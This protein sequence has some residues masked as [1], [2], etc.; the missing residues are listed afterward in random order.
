[1]SYYKSLNFFFILLIA[2]SILTN[3]IPIL[4]DS[5]MEEQEILEVNVPRLRGN[6]TNYGYETFSNGTGTYTIS[7]DGSIVQTSTFNSYYNPEPRFLIF[8]E[9]GPPSNDL[10]MRCNF[11]EG[12]GTDVIINDGTLAGVINGTTNAGW[13]SSLDESFNYSHV[14]DETS[15]EHINFTDRDEL[16]FDKAG[17]AEDKPFTIEF[18]YSVTWAFP[19]FK[20]IFA[21]ANYTSSVY[22]WDFLL[23]DEGY[24]NFNLYDGDGTGATFETTT[25]SQYT[26]DNEWTHVAFSYF[27]NLKTNNSA[28]RIY[29]NGT[30]QTTSTISSGTQAAYGG[31]N[32]TDSDFSLGRISGGY[33]DGWFDEF[34]IWNKS[35]TASEIS[36]LYNNAPLL[37]YNASLD[38]KTKLIESSPYLYAENDSM[39]W[40]GDDM[41]DWINQ[42]TPNNLTAHYDMETG[43]GTTLYDVENNHDATF[44]GDIQWNTTSVNALANGSIYFD[45][46]D[47]FVRIPD[48]DDF[49]FTNGTNYFDIPYS[50]DLWIYPHSV[51]SYRT[52]IQK[53]ESDTSGWEEWRLIIYDGELVFY[54]IPDWDIGEMIWVQT[55]QADLTAYN[56]YHITATYD[57]SENKN[58]LEVYVNGEVQPVTRWWQ[59]MTGYIGMKNG[60]TEVIMGAHYLGGQ[61]V[62]EFVGN[63]DE[64]RIWR[65][66]LGASE[67]YTMYK[68][69][70]YFHVDRESL[71]INCTVTYNGTAGLSHINLTQSWWGDTPEYDLTGANFDE[72]H[73]IIQNP[74]FELP[75]GGSTDPD[76]WTGLRQ[77]TGQARTGSWHGKVTLSPNNLLYQSIDYWPVSMVK[78]VTLWARKDGAGEAI[79]N[80]Y[81]T[82]SDATQS[83]FYLNASTTSYEKFTINQTDLEYTKI[84]TEL[85][86][87][88]NT[89]YYIGLI[90]DV[91]IYLQPMI[92]VSLDLDISQYDTQTG[93]MCVSV[94]SSNPHTTNSTIEIDQDT[95]G[96]V[97]RMTTGI[98]TSNN[99]YYNT[100]H[101]HTD[102]YFS[103]NM[104]ATADNFVING[105]AYDIGGSGLGIVNCTNTWGETAPSNSGTNTSWSFSWPIDESWTEYGQIQHIDNPDFEDGN[106]DWTISGGSISGTNERRSHSGAYFLYL[107]AYSNA[108]AYQNVNDIPVDDVEYLYFWLYCNWHSLETF[109]RYAVQLTV[110]YN[111]TTSTAWNF[112]AQGTDNY[113]QMIVDTADLSAGKFIS[114]IRFDDKLPNTMGHLIYIDDV[115]LYT[116]FDNITDS[117]SITAYDNVGNPQD[118]FNYS[119]DLLFYVKFDLFA[120][121]QGG[122]GVQSRTINDSSSYDWPIYT[123]WDSDSGFNASSFVPEAQHSMC[124]NQTP[125]DWMQPSVSTKVGD[126]DR[127]AF[128]SSTFTLG[129][130]VNIA[131]LET[132]STPI[133]IFYR[134]Q[135]FWVDINSQNY[136]VGGVR[137]VDFEL[138]GVGTV[139]SAYFIPMNQWTFVVLRWNGSEG[140]IFFNGT[141]DVNTITG[142]YNP[143]AGDF[144]VVFGN[145]YA[146]V[147]Y[148]YYLD[149]L[150]FYTTSLSDERIELMYHM[151]PFSPSG[152]NYDDTPFTDDYDRITFGFTNDETAPSSGASFDPM[153]AFYE[154]GDTDETYYNLTSD[155][156]WFSNSFD[157][158][159]NITFEANV[160]DLGAGM[161]GVDYGTFGDDDPAEDQTTPY[162]GNYTINS[163]DS[164][165]YLTVIAYDNVGNSATETLYCYEDGTALW[166]NIT[167]ETENSIYLY[168]GYG[169]GTQGFYGSAMGATLQAFNISG[170]TYTNVT[171]LNQTDFEG[172]FT[173][174]T[175]WTRSGEEGRSTVEWEGTYAMR[176]T[177]GTSPNYDD[178]W[179][180]QTCWIYSD[181]IA[182]LT[183]MLR[184]RADCDAYIVF[185]YTDGSNTTQYFDGSRDE[186]T[187]EQHAISPLPAGKTINKIRFGSNYTAPSANMVLID[188]IKLTLG[189]SG[190]NF[191]DNSTFGNN[192][193][194]GG[195]IDNWFFVYQIDEN[196]NGNTTVAFVSYDNVGNNYSRN[197]LFYEDNVAPNIDHDPSNT[198]ETSP[199][200]YY[201]NDNQTGYYSENMP[202]GTDP[203]ENYL[204]LSL[205]FDEGTGS[206]TYDSSDESRTITEVTWDGDEWN[207]TSYNGQANYSFNCY[208]PDVVWAAWDGETPDTHAWSVGGWFALDPTYWDGLNNFWSFVDWTWY[209]DAFKFYKHAN[210]QLFIY[211]RGTTTTG[212][213]GTTTM[214][215]TQAF[216]TAWNF[217]VV[218]WDGNIA[219]DPKLYVNGT[220]IALTEYAT[221]SGSLRDSDRFY[222]GESTSA[223][224]YGQ[225]DSIFVYNTNISATRIADMYGYM[226]A[227]FQAGESFFVGG[228][229]S[230]ALGITDAGVVDNTTAFLDPSNAGTVS[231]WSFEYKIGYTDGAT[232]GTINVTYTVIDWVGNSNTTWFYF[233]FDNQGPTAVLESDPEATTYVDNYHSDQTV[234][235]TVSSITDGF[236][237]TGSGLNQSYIRWKLDGGSWG[238]WN[239]TTIR[240]YTL[241]EGE[242]IFYI[243]LRDNVTNIREYNYTIYVDLTD[244]IIGI[245]L[246]LDTLVNGGFESGDDGNWTLYQ[247]SYSTQALR[248]HSGTYGMQV[249]VYS[250]G[251]YYDGYIE[252][253][254][255]FY[256]D[257][258]S[259]FT[260][261]ERSTDTSGQTTWKVTFHYSDGTSNSWSISNHEDFNW[262]QRTVSGWSSGK[263]LMWF[264]LETI[265]D[266]GDNTGLSA[267]DDIVISGSFTDVTTDELTW[268]DP[269]Y[270]T[271][272]YR[273]IDDYANFNVTWTELYPYRV[274]CSNIP[275]SYAEDDGPAPYP[276]GNVSDFTITIT[277][278]ADGYYNIS[279]TI[280]DR[281]GRKSTVYTTSDNPNNLIIDNTGP[282]ISVFQLVQHPEALVSNYYKTT[283][284]ETTLSG[285]S[286]GVN[287]SGLH[288]SGF[289]Y[290][291][292]VN[293]DGWQSWTAV[294]NKIWTTYDQQNNTLKVMARDNLGWNSSVYLEWVISDTIAPDLGWLTL[295]E[296]YAPNWFDQ[297]VSTAAGVTIYWT[298]PYPFNVTLGVSPFLPHTNDTSP[299][300]GVS[301]LWVNITG[302]SDGSYALSVT[303]WDNAGNS[304]NTLT[305]S[306]AP[307]NLE[308]GMSTRDIENWFYFYFFRADGIGLDWR[309]FNTS[310]ILDEN[311][312]PYVE[313]RIRGALFAQKYLNLTSSIRFVVRNY[314]GDTVHNQSYTLPTS[315]DLYITL[316][317]YTFKVSNLYDEVMNM[318]IRR[319]SS[320]TIYRE[321]LMPYE[322]FS[323]DMYA[324]VYNITVYIHDTSIIALDEMGNQLIDYQVNLTISDFALF[325]DAP[326]TFRELNMI[327]SSIWQFNL[328]TNKDHRAVQPSIYIYLNDSLQGGGAFTPGTVVLSRPTYGYYNLTIYAVWQSY[329]FTYQ[330]WITVESNA[331]LTNFV[332]AGLEEANDYLEISWNTNKGTGRLTIK[333]NTST[334][335]IFA[336]EGVSELRKSTVVGLH[337]LQFII[338]VE[339]LSFDDLYLNY[340]IPDWT[341]IVSISLQGE[342]DG[343]VTMYEDQTIVATVTRSDGATFN[344]LV[345]INGTSFTITSGTGSIV[346]AAP[347]DDGEGWRE[348][349]YVVTDVQDGVGSSRDY[350]ANDLDVIWDALQFSV[351]LGDPQVY[352]DE[353]ASFF[354]NIT[355]KYDDNPSSQFSFN[356]K[357]NDTFIKSVTTT[358]FE[359]TVTSAGT[360]EI[361]IEAIRDHIYDIDYSSGF[362]I[363]TF[364]AIDRVTPA[365]ERATQ[366]EEL[367][368]TAAQ[369]IVILAVAIAAIIAYYRVV[370]PTWRRWQMGG[371]YKTQTG[372]QIRRMTGKHKIQLDSNRRRHQPSGVR[373]RPRLSSR[374]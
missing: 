68:S 311:Y 27:G 246:G 210:D 295:N 36:W 73:N 172:S 82:Y 341:A 223:S 22:E 146:N 115:Y 155:S 66:E 304:D 349:T 9:G 39:L 161:R 119:E 368:R 263:V 52:L 41:V 54:C 148:D 62:R 244:P 92:E 237:A 103:D 43:Y 224:Y 235:A 60:N 130:W 208:A 144:S 4:S 285:A 288:D 18:W 251:M 301:N 100:T 160:T 206:D 257:E 185:F 259:S 76:H 78:N 98:E 253:N 184:D 105:T 268:I 80:T 196:D 250:G 104:G 325:V 204:N 141:K 70:P 94:W 338:D 229:A 163:T 358:E 216:Y 107:N 194:N 275:L 370:R 307:I 135:G 334:V 175:N 348:L 3:A 328:I 123:T 282:T 337:M 281:S 10:T 145:R 57:G 47:D 352:V 327:I 132:T 187:Y 188:Y 241:S 174:G 261:Y 296:S 179:I 280:F 154:V 344:G 81:I 218:T 318:T 323:W 77:N 59:G 75:A 79:I 58:G 149:D 274:N 243:Q 186:N 72:N 227:L 48:H 350:V 347:P 110:E 114:R 215:A 113:E 153:S 262:Y 286:D 65:R 90:D 265:H 91:A 2:S 354:V 180:E 351:E 357:L 369:W 26:H 315:F 320:A 127:D 74:S 35:L 7:T 340:T 190:D 117:T 256:T 329:D 303:M 124:W 266:N 374:R 176:I 247:S 372:Q 42:T 319:P 13:D 342:T 138:Y 249:S 30:Y 166:V 209:E 283:A 264:R 343:R 299:S 164:G 140:A 20:S 143:T 45:G 234:N 23:D 156:F 118:D 272:F 312:R 106:Q 136:A 15:Q 46:S 321:Q 345:E 239:T 278:A 361:K 128:G 158:D 125:A 201:P 324:A 133:G 231:N 69:S 56:W 335:A 8:Q 63:M 101:Y 168:A 313:Q 269:S 314:F 365:A 162:H 165:V 252:Q 44:N 55:T 29:V 16:S 147:D 37:P 217:Y 198:N 49:T 99:L 102:G 270:G 214:P 87:E 213:W 199:Y 326:L 248:V 279:A 373:N 363:R 40:Y 228:T 360:W 193:T 12:S 97:M 189:G 364:T 121:G 134:D 291:Y 50:I 84:I 183:F 232:Y 316:D 197:Y 330:R 308:S 362:K 53:Y 177:N 83:K 220:E 336:I 309:D 294:T 173:W 366:E 25:W 109:D 95:I 120:S 131:R 85:R 108:Y 322:I 159:T 230:D 202:P 276:S 88:Y 284:P 182:S 245:Y 17:S 287:G 317:V 242:H 236:P 205:L 225:I 126:P 207:A 356:V 238:V 139:R 211:I 96:P 181:M 233:Y 219:N 178:G 19:I 170:I 260:F 332:V 258:I 339:S 191:N 150:F 310:Y 302:A 28:G 200:L 71:Q 129:F 24:L 151:M 89:S 331:E 359:I 112:T 142:T 353:P 367:G 293:N 6:S 306:E 33:M 271:Q 292:Q 5:D 346:I 333:D 297:S 38:I 221:I 300:G 226:P 273:A 192:P 51:S 167:G 203:Y 277:G 61:W 111:D 86:F 31:M 195:T 371:E 254:V 152:D 116:A 157:S 137:E 289:I 32:N 93:T 64:V 169:N 14:F 255:T 298:E 222:V 290:I 1:M 21:K 171:I 122:G 212:L 240:N 305:G 34:R 355:Y 267:V 11:N 67:I